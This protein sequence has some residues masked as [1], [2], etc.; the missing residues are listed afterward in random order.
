MRIAILGSVALPV[1][2]PMQGGTEWIA[3]HQAEGLTNSGHS[4]ILFAAKGSKAGK[5]K[6]VE[7]GGGDTVVGSTLAVNKDD[8]F[9]ESSRKLRLENVYLSQVMQRLIELKDEYDII[10]NNMRGE[11]VFI[12]LAKILNKKFVNVMHLPLF[13]QLA[14]FFRENR[15][16]IITISNAQRKD[17]PDLNY[18][19]T[20][21]NCVDVN[22]FR[23]NATPEDYILMVGSISPHKN[24]EGAIRIAKKLG[25]NLVLAGKIGDKEYYKKIQKD[26]DG[27]QIEWVGELGFEAKHR[28][29]QK[30][31]AFIFPILWEEPF[32]LVM[33]EAMAC[34][35]PVV[36]F[37]NGAIPEVVKDGLTGFVIPENDEYR[38][39]EALKNIGKIKRENCRKY[40]EENFSVGKMVN[41]YETLL[42]QL[43]K[44]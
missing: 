5:Y 4:V 15:T 2:P 11:A 36:A 29:Y 23:F 27:R 12:P 3:Y 28:L 7:V 26:M 9:I 32:G 43:S 35:T 30:A 20:V 37:A 10:L 8:E 38:M 25:L 24:Q 41:G 1:P 6:L 31:K 18:L 42:N 40:V 21:S 39:A 19:G 16:E 44:G 34:G 22:E 14:S 33:I 17:F 13:P